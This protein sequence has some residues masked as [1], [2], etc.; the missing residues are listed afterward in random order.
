MSNEAM[1]LAT[2]GVSVSA[3]TTVMMGISVSK[4][5]SSC[6]E[7]KQIQMTVELWLV[8]LKISYHCGIRPAQL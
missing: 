8:S 6:K 7:T 3:H 5:P 4:Q 1:R 2:V